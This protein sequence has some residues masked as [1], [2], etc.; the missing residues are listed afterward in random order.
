[1]GEDTSNAETNEEIAQIVARTG[2]TYLVWGRDGKLYPF[3]VG[4]DHV[5]PEPLER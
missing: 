5:I 2:A 4:V 3:K 1:V